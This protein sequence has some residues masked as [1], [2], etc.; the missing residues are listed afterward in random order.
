MLVKDK[1]GLVISCWMFV[2]HFQLN[3]VIVFNLR[4]FHWSPLSGCYVNEL[5]IGI[6]ILGIFRFWLVAVNGTH[7]FCQIPNTYICIYIHISLS[8]CG[9]MLLVIL[10]FGN[11]TSTTLPRFMQSY[12]WPMVSTG[13]EFLVAGCVV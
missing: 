1:C 2:I 7:G 8:E 10:G 3:V 5:S 12:R 13:L 6:T 4:G 9:K 11:F